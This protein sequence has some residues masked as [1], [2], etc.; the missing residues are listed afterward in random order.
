MESH[1]S[2]ISESLIKSSSIVRCEQFWQIEGAVCSL[3]IYWHSLHKF[4]VF[5]FFFQLKNA[6]LPGEFDVFCT[7]SFIAFVISRIQTFIFIG[8]CHYLHN[9][10]LKIVQNHY[11]TYI[12]YLINSFITAIDFVKL[13]ISIIN[14]FDNYTQ[15][16]EPMSTKN[17]LVS[18]NENKIFIYVLSIRNNVL[19]AIRKLTLV[20][21][22]PFAPG[23]LYVVHQF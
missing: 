2:L 14:I 19:S 20:K 13:G 11:L 1:S 10:R 7:G 22:N 5:R 21:I 17:N 12:F 9:H 8:M 15:Y 23:D 18:H 3:H 6:H 4:D 16:G